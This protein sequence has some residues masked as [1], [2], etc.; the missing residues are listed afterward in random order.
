MPFKA[1][2]FTGK[3]AIYHKVVEKSAELFGGVN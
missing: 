1:M 3:F 2:L